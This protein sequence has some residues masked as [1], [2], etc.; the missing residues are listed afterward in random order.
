MKLFWSLNLI[1][2][3]FCCNAQV[4][5][6][7]NIVG[8]YYYRCSLSSYTLE[9]KKDSSF[10][11]N[12]HRSSL[13]NIWGSTSGEWKFKEN[14]IILNSKRDSVIEKKYKAEIIESLKKSDSTTLKFFNIKGE[15]ITDLYCEIL[16]DNNVIETKFPNSKGIV[17]FL[18]NKSDFVKV[19]SSALESKYRSIKIE[20]HKNINCYDI[21][22]KEQ[23]GFN[24]THLENIDFIVK[25]GT[26]FVPEN[27]IQ[28]KCNG[29]LYKMK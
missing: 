6:K 7:N 9:I 27:R 17:K 13:F 8:I 14:K 1:L 11:Y 15:I 28:K 19:F 24:I 5:E 25:N 21:T 26:L 18:N 4:K 29:Y 22:L 12:W 3:C 20:L 16:Q 2:I 10:Q 23:D